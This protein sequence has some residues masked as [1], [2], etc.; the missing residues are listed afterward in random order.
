MATSSC[1]SS[2]SGVRSLWD[3]G[4]GLGLA[5]FSLQAV[6]RLPPSDSGSEAGHSL[7]VSEDEKESRDEI[8]NLIETLQAEVKTLREEKTRAGRR[9]PHT[10]QHGHRSRV[11]DV[12]HLGGAGGRRERLRLR[13]FGR[14]PCPA[15]SGDDGTAVDSLLR[16]LKEHETAVHMDRAGAACARAPGDSPSVPP[17]LS[18]SSA[19]ATAGSGDVDTA[20]LRDALRDPHE[21]VLEQLEGLKPAVDWSLP[22]NVS[23]RVAPPL[24]VQIFSTHPSATQMAQRWVQDKQL[25]RNHVA[26]EMLLMCMVLDKSLLSVRDFFNTEGCEIIA[27]RIYANAFENV[28]NASDWRQPK[29]AAGSKWKS[30]L[31]WDL[32]NEIDLRALSGEMEALPGI[33]KELQCRLK[34][35]ALL[36]KHVGQAAAVAGVAEEL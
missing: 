12:L 2:S 26:H 19:A 4:F 34:D 10:R 33:D 7:P 11:G 8:K 6:R 25:E 24:L 3:G 16:R 32:A 36:T 30:K 28:R 9:R 18:R 35:R 23:E 1:P 13:G 22:A 5:G 15:E 20:R 14:N 21:R 31:R 17:G 27:R 29:G